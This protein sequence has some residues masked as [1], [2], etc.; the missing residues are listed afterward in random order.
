MYEWVFIDLSESL[1]SVSSRGRTFRLKSA[2]RA[3][4]CHKDV[5]AVR[6][7]AI[8]LRAERVDTLEA[9]PMALGPE[10]E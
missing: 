5:R 3:V 10:R 1:F 8:V 9:E 6:E 7:R 4:F 2:A